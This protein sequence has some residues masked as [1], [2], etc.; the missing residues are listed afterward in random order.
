MKRFGA[1]VAIAVGLERPSDKGGLLDTI[2]VIEENDDLLADSLSKL[3]VGLESLD[4]R[5]PAFRW[6][7]C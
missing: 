3:L 7:V 4:H 1:Y 6:D 5:T 2:Q